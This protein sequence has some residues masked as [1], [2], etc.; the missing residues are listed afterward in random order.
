M[1]ERF[2]NWCERLNLFLEDARHKEFKRGQ[3]DCALFVCDA[4]NTMTGVD[5]GKDLRNTYKTKKEAFEAVRSKGCKDLIQLANK[6]LGEPLQTPLKAGRGD[7]V[8][9]KYGDELGLAVVDLTGR[10][11]VTPSLKKLEFYPAKYW[12]K[13]WKV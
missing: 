2:E 8:A 7:I 6:K 4:I 3:H 5:F 10:F 13:A 9:V 12:L 11:A 1:V